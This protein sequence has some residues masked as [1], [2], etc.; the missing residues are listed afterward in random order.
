MT[1]QIIESIQ[2]NDVCQNITKNVPQIFFTV[3]FLVVNRVF[4]VGLKPLEVKYWFKGNCFNLSAS[5]L[6]EEKKKNVFDPSGE[7]SLPYFIRFHHFLAAFWIDAR[8]FI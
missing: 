2:K 4:F 3:V 6:V 8:K 1:L 5:N 7:M